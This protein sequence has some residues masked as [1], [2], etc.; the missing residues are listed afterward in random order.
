MASKQPTSQ[1]LAYLD[2]LK[3]RLLDLRKRQRSFMDETAQILRTINNDPA[4]PQPKTASTISFPVAPKAETQ[5]CGGKIK[6]LIKRFEDLR[7][8]SR[9]FSDQTLP[10]EL[11]GVDV[12][13]LLRG[14]EKLILEGNILQNSWLLLRKTT[15]SC[16]RQT[17][18][19]APN[20]KTTSSKSSSFAEQTSDSPENDLS[21]APIGSSQSQQDPPIEKA[22][23]EQ[24]DWMEWSDGKPNRQRFGAVL[25]L[26]L[27]IFNRGCTM[28]C[29]RV[30]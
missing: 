25:H 23:S 5:D 18:S 27:R 14:Y 26:L 17:N 1:Q 22:F 2:E 19:D 9:Q 20:L 8:T 6:E 7:Q 15:E 29:R 11:V 30:R 21:S 13:K 10:D 24:S 12:R 16:A 28:K 3:Q 4:T